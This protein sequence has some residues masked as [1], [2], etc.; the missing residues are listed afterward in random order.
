MT[1]EDIK[2]FVIGG[3]SSFYK[4]QTGYG[5]KTEGVQQYLEYIDSEFKNAEFFSTG[6]SSNISENKLLD[7]DQDRLHSQSISDPLSFIVDL[8][9]N[10]YSILFSTTA[11]ETVSIIYVPSMFSFLISIPLLY[12][13]D[14]L[15]LYYMSDTEKVIWGKNSI[16][17]RAKDKLY[18]TL[19]DFLLDNCDHVLYRDK[20]VSNRSKRADL[21]FT[22]SKPLIA[23]DSQ[24]IFVRNDTCTSNSIQILFVGSLIPR[25]GIRYLLK[26]ACEINNE[27]DEFEFKIVIVGDGSERKSL[28]ETA[29]DIGISDEVEFKGHISNNDTL[30]QI[31]RDSDIFVLPSLEEGFPRV[32]VEA[33]SQSLPVITTN[34][35]EIPDRLDENEALLISSES[36]DELTK[37]IQKIVIN[38]ELRRRLITNGREKADSILTSS[39]GEQHSSI[40]KS[41]SKK[42]T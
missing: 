30:K 37:A 23:I 26:S 36:T 18:H 32:I 14:S 20:A 19:D 28:I 5:V 40:I 27:L 10:T 21:P 35:G 38:P 22:R 17:N 3:T 7:I 2:V 12:K 33:M 15:I 24:D 1:E 31:Y 16:V 34:V 41:L 6:A 42:S 4:N 8:I 11:E 9:R 13:S 29:E 39:A 25:K